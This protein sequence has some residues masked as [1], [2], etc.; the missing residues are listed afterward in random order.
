MKG[1]GTGLC[2]QAKTLP[3][4]A[5]LNKNPL[6]AFSTGPDRLT[7]IMGDEFEMLVYLSIH[8]DRKQRLIVSLEDTRYRHIFLLSV[9]GQIVEI[10]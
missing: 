10:N 4:E 2:P 3:R 1:R 9:V 6:S 8:S 7:G 5:D